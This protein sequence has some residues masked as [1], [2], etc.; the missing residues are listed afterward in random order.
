MQAVFAPLLESPAGIFDDLR[1]ERFLS[2]RAAIISAENVPDVLDEAGSNRMSTGPML[3]ESTV[4]L[5]RAGPEGVS[6]EVDLQLE[7]EDGGD[8]APANPLIDVQIPDELGAGIALPEADVGIELAGA[9]AGRAPS[10]LGDSVA[11]YPNVAQDT[12][13]AISPTPN[14]VETLTQLRTPEAPLSQTF[15]LALPAGAELRANEL[16]GAEAT[17]NGDPLVVVSPP[18]ALDAVGGSVP[19]SLAVAGDSLV[20]TVEPEP[21]TSYPIAVDPSIQDAYNWYYDGHPG[22][23]SY[24]TPSSVYGNFFKEP[25]T[26]CST[27]C[28]LRVAAAP[29]GYAQNSQ[30]YWQYAVPRFYTDFASYGER[31]RSWVQAYNLGYITFTGGGEYQANP[32]AIFAVS[33]QNGAWRSSSIYPP[34]LSGSYGVNLNADHSGR[35]ASFG[36]FTTS[37]QGIYTERYLLTGEAQ[38]VLGDE[39]AP[40]FGTV[41]S[42]T[43]WVNTEAKP[44]NA[45]IS[46]TGL[47]VRKLFVKNP[48]GEVIGTTA[49]NNNCVGTVRSTCPRVWKGAQEGNQVTY[50]PSGLPQGINN[51]TLEAVD[52]TGNASSTALQVKVDHTAPGLVLS[53]TMTQQSTIGKTLPQYTLQFN[54]SDG[55]VANPQSGIT[56]AEMKIDGTK[57]KEWAPGCGLQ[58]C[59]LSGEWTLASSSYS[60]GVHFGEVTVTDGAGLKASKSVF[61]EIQR[62]TVAPTLEATKFFYTAPDGWLE[63]QSYSN[64]AA[65]Q[66]PKG[67]GVT[68]L[69]LKIDGSVVTSV[70][71]TCG[72][73]SCGKSFSGGTTGMAAYEGGAHEAEL[74][75]VDGAGN[76]A[77]KA[78]TIN[79][80]P[81]GAVPGAEAAATVGAADVTAETGLVASSEEAISGEE[82]EEGND[83]RLVRDGDELASVGVPVPVEYS[84]DP[85]A[86]VSLQAPEGPIGVTPVATGTGEPS[87][88]VVNEA[89]SVSAGLSE[90]DTL[91]RPIYNGFMNFEA[92]RSFEAPEAFSWMIELGSGQYLEQVTEQS[93]GLFYED[94]T[95]AMTINAESAHDAVG[96]PVPTAL[97][98]SAADQVTLTVN[99][100]GGQYVYPVLAGPSFQAPYQAYVTVQPTLEPKPEEPAPEINN[101]LVL[102]G[103]IG[104]PV[105]LPLTDTDSDGATASASRPHYKMPFEWDLCPTDLSIFGSHPGCWASDLHIEGV[106]EFNSRYAW[107]KESKPHPRCPNTSH[108]V[109]ENLIYCNWAGA[110]HQKYGGG[111]HISALDEVN[112]TGF[113]GATFNAPEHLMMY[114]Y[115]DGYAKGHNTNHVCNPLSNCPG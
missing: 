98:K 44:F 33:D 54:A 91:V 81:S 96:T 102:G 22:W 40:V 65:A 76:V 5:R 6:E 25:D 115:G 14:G 28:F 1:V 24:R 83:P 66:D 11:F 51:L 69:T 59:A 47:G 10:L 34:N 15:N 114:M 39:T 12:D 88:V 32:G 60:A 46:D 105:M 71:G 79:V 103:S 35:L 49:I 87:T 42:P 84:T 43:E 111:Y 89:A 72:G 2:D 112:V 108:V 63:Q 4:P 23:T 7:T 77:R 86:G 26:G 70:S 55:T 50:N 36:L 94:G 19:V 29:G 61:F 107:W 18:T 38:V 20:V 78:W 93:V 8:L 74:V 45:T 30:A 95:L 3:L 16:G 99:H 80:N 31:P 106:F 57:V 21:S 109:S 113:A 85:S 48:A 37:L 100:R 110:N 27:Y 101:A 97:Q 82:R 17:L 68:S 90:A 75:A 53:G 104:P 52:P 56:K 67:Y 58:N 64:D 73:G 92:I 62:D 41:S 13:L 9:P